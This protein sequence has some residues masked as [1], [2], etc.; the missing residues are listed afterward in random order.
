MP[1]TPE[2]ALSLS[3]F[4]D[5]TPLIGE[6][7]DEFTY[8]VLFDPTHPSVSDFTPTD[9]QRDFILEIW[10]NKRPQTLTQLAK[11]IKFIAVDTQDT[12]GQ[13]IQLLRAGNAGVTNAIYNVFKQQIP[14]L[15]AELPPPP[16]PS[17]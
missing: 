5:F 15:V 2:Q 17:V 9:P 13:V 4:T 3:S 10:D 1:L 11:I 12:A 7:L 14:K 6:Y 8:R 16:P